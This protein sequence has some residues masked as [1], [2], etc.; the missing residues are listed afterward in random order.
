M[1]E[2][3]MKKRKVNILSNKIN[4]LLSIKHLEINRINGG[5]Y[6]REIMD[7][8]KESGKSSKI[9]KRPSMGMLNE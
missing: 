1:K 3:I 7:K 8:I 6:E 5:F 4:T 2:E 9:T